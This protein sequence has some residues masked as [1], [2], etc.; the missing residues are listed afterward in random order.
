MVDNEI[1]FEGAMDHFPSSFN[2]KTI[3]PEFSGKMLILDC[4]LAVTRTTT[5]DKVFIMMSSAS[6]YVKPFRLYWFLIIRKH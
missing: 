3:Q 6:M 2:S 5:N 4:L 1:G